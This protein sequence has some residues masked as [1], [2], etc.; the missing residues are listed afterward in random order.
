M[1]HNVTISRQSEVRVKLLE[2]DG[3]QRADLASEPLSPNVVAQLQAKQQPSARRLRWTIE[4]NDPRMVG[5][6][7]TTLRPQG[8]QWIARLDAFVAVR[9]GVVDAFELEGSGPWTAPRM[10]I[11][12]A[13]L[14]V[15]DSAA[16]VKQMT[17]TPRGAPANRYHFACEGTIASARFKVPAFRLLGAENVQQY[18]RLPQSEH[19]SWST[20]GAQEASLPAVANSVL[21][22]DDLQV[23][24]AV[25]PRLQIE[26]LGNEPT[27]PSPRVVW[28]SVQ[29]SPRGD[30]SYVAAAEAAVDPAGV[31]FLPIRLPADA[32][33]VQTSIDGEAALAELRGHRRFVV[34]LRSSELPQMVRIVYAGKLG[35]DTDTSSLMP[36]FDSWKVEDALDIVVDEPSPTPKLDQIVPLVANALREPPQPPDEL[37]DWA[38]RWLS[39]LQAV[40]VQ[41]AETVTEAENEQARQVMQQLEAIADA[42]TMLEQVAEQPETLPSSRAATPQSSVSAWLVALAGWLGIVAVGHRVSRSGQL[43]ELA[44][45]WPA[46]WAALV[47]LTVAILLSPWI[48][49]ALLAIAAISSFSWPWPKPRQ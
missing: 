24:R 44:Q 33:L 35:P 5:I 8:E 28:G 37:S 14:Q 34:P 1:A 39:R 45:R 9:D 19:Y 16:A 12:D 27:L 49:G 18:V 13:T 11:G 7:V 43:V 47:A 46:G 32:L 36:G 6:L 10:I 48:G 25:V 22:S 15:N 26:L 4:R 3:F 38:S 23:Y 30:A 31:Q 17:I 20:A 42:G 40:Q 41:A 29:L 2:Q 21:A